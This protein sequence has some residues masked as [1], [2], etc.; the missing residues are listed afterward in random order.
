MSELEL[1]IWIA[2]IFFVWLKFLGTT[3]QEPKIENYWKWW[4][5][6]KQINNNA[7]I[8]KKID[9]ENLSLENLQI[10]K[11][12]LLNEIETLEFESDTDFEKQT[13]NSTKIKK[14]KLKI[15]HIKISIEDKYNNI[16]DLN[17]ELKWMY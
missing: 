2:I 1:A 4:E 3:I 10:Q 8:Y 9:K 16:H 15:K 6:E 7:K 11:E 5:V 13:I 17:W 14:L 12:E